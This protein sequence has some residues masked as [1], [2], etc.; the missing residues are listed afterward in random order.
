MLEYDLAPGRSIPVGFTLGYT[1]GFPEDDPGAGLAGVL[2]GI[3]YTGREA[4][5]IGAET[6]FMQLPAEGDAEKLDALLGLLTIR[7]YF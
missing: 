4:F 7:Y 2:V 6:G 5:T 3:W 1:K